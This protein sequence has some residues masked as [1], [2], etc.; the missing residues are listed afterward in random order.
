MTVQDQQ[1]PSGVQVF[2]S[3]ADVRNKRKLKNFFVKPKFQLKY[4]YYQVAAGFSFFGTT[5]FL[6]NRKLMEIDVVLQNNV[7]I[8]A[9]IQQQLHNIYTDITKITLIGFACYVAFTFVYA[10][11]LTH[12][13]SGPMISIVTFIDELKKGNYGFKRKLRRA[14]ELVPIS[15]SLHELA[16]LLLRKSTNDQTKNVE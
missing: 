2:S 10:M 6:I 1:V 3:P 14:D 9:L 5:V 4:T 15:E 16:Q 13:V 7:V 12:R 8:D 11:L